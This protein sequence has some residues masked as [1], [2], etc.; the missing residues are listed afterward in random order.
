MA[1]LK[2]V[3]YI[4]DLITSNDVNKFVSARE[5][6]NYFEEDGKQAF[7][8]VRS[9]L[10]G[11]SPYFYR[12]KEAGKVYYRLGKNGKN[13]LNHFIDT[14]DPITDTVIMKPLEIEMI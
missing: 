6:S 5:I 3:I 1:T 14:Y 7:E 13:Y 10:N 9:Q 4:L 12:K 8:R 2:K 11:C